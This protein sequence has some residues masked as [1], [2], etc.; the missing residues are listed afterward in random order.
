[1]RTAVF[2]ELMQVDMYDDGYKMDWSTIAKTCT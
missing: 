2:Y 1:M